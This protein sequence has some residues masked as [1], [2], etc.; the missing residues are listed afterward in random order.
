MM[1]HKLLILLIFFMSIAAHSEPI[2]KPYEVTNVLAS[3]YFF[4][5]YADMTAAW[6]EDNPDDLEDPDDPD[7]ILSGFSYCEIN[8]EHNI[9][10]CEIY[11][12]RPI[13]VDGE[14]TTTIGHE[15][16]HGIYGPEYHE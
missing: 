9:S 10:Y 7:A 14:H 4:D 12:V 1:K 5:N 2:A 6:N 15:I 13:E 8:V 3:F 11:V 16:E